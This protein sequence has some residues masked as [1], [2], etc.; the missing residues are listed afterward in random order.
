MNTKNQPKVNDRI[1]EIRERF[2]E[3]SNKRF[4]DKLEISAQRMSN[5]CNSDTAGKEI[6]DRILELNPQI[7]KCWMYCGVGPMLVG[8]SQHNTATDCSAN[9]IQSPNAIT[10]INAAAM[11]EITKNNEFL[12]E[13]V[14]ELREIMKMIVKQNQTPKSNGNEQ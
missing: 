8:D 13:E 7:N 6:M 3:N 10:T 14:R 11:V 4:A 5:L 12:I 1:K 9:V 2:Y